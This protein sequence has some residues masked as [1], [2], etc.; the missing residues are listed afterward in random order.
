MTEPLPFR[1]APLPGEALPSWLGR[2]GQR[3]DLDRVD[4]LASAFGP[5]AP[6]ALAYGG[7]AQPPAELTRTIASRTSVTDCAVRATTFASWAGLAPTRER[8]RIPAFADTLVHVGDTTAIC[9]RCLASNATPYVRKLWTLTFVAVCPMHRTVLIVACRRCKQRPSI[10]DTLDSRR[11][12]RWCDTSFDEGPPAHP[13]AAHW[14]ARLLSALYRGWIAPAH[15]GPLPWPLLINAVR[16]IGVIWHVAGGVDRA[17]LA[18]MI[19]ASVGAVVTPVNL[20]RI[21]VLGALERHDALL[22]VGWLLENWPMRMI[23]TAEQIGLTRA[24]RTATKRGATLKAAIH[25]MPWR[26]SCDLAWRTSGWDE[27]SRSAIQHPDYLRTLRRYFHRCGATDDD[28]MNLWEPRNLKRWDSS[29]IVRDREKWPEPTWRP[30][31]YVTNDYRRGVS[32]SR[33]SC[34]ALGSFTDSAFGTGKG[35]IAPR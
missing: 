30:A 5:R 20:G 31:T 21:K 1:L 23:M 13:L 2:I 22:T 25:R 15:I 17:R 24:R 32:I 19:G 4:L 12:C 27:P 11:R 34:Q 28:G 35:L 10:M 7:W 29:E 9:P 3:Y 33:P 16:E 18:A 8:M 6:R 26:F 14:Q